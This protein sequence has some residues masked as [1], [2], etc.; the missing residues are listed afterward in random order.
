MNKWN[1][2]RIKY[3]NFLYFAVKKIKMPFWLEISFYFLI[4]F[5][6]IVGVCYLINKLFL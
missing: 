1:Y 2:Y 5:A 6:E 3:I 4:L